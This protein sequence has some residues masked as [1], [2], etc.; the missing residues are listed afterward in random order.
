MPFG[1]S[2]SDTPTLAENLG[3]GL[4][5]RVK[6]D[7]KINQLDLYPQIGYTNKFPKYALA[8]KFNSITGET[9]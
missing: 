9:I 7:I 6:G 1:V 3:W 4:G 2:N 5:R 8:Y